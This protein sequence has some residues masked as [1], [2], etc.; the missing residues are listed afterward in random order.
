MVKRFRPLVNTGI[1]HPRDLPPSARSWSCEDLCVTPADGGDEAIFWK[2]KQRE[3]E[4]ISTLSGG[5]WVQH[6]SDEL[7]ASGISEIPEWYFI[8]SKGLKSLTVQRN[9]LRLLPDAIGNLKTIDTIVCDDNEIQGVL[10][11]SIGELSRLTGFTC[12]RN[13]LSG[14]VPS[15]FSNLTALSVLNLNSNRLAGMLPSLVRIR[16]DPVLDVDISNNFFSGL[17]EDIGDSINLYSL[18]AAGN[19]LRRLPRSIGR[20][21]SL[22]SIDLLDFSN[23][24]LDTVPRL[25]GVHKTLTKLKLANNE[26]KS[27]AGL[28][29]LLAGG[30]L[31]QLLLSGNQFSDVPAGIDTDGAA[32]TLLDM[33]RNPT[34]CKKVFGPEDGA[35]KAGTKIICKCADGFDG[36][37]CT[38]SDDPKTA[39]TRLVGSIRGGLLFADGVIA[40]AGQSSNITLELLSFKEGQYNHTHTLDANLDQSGISFDRCTD[41]YW[42]QKD[43]Y[44]AEIVPRYYPSV[45]DP[46]Q[47]LYAPFISD[48]PLSLYF[49]NVLLQ[50]SA[51]GADGTP[52]LLPSHPPMALVRSAFNDP[53]SAPYIT[54]TFVV[55]TG[56]TGIRTVVLPALL[57]DRLKGNPNIPTN[58]TISVKPKDADVKLCPSAVVTTLSVC[59]YALCPSGISGRIDANSNDWILSFP[60][61]T[62]GCRGTVVA[63]E[64]VS[65]ETLDVMDVEISPVGCFA[66]DPADPRS[67]TC[68]STGHGRCNTKGTGSLC[69]CDFGY[70]K[71]DGTECSRLKTCTGQ[72]VLS[73]T[74][75]DA[76]SNIPECVSCAKGAIPSDT[77]SACVPPACLDGCSCKFDKDG[78]EGAS[79]TVKCNDTRA[80]V[81]GAKSLPSMTAVLDLTDI[82]STDVDFGTILTPA[83]SS[84]PRMLIVDDRSVPGFVESE[85]RPSVIEIRLPLLSARAISAVDWALLRKTFSP[86][87]LPSGD[88]PDIRIVLSGRDGKPCP[89]GT[90][91]NT[92]GSGCEDCPRGQFFGFKVG[93][94]GPSPEIGCGSCE[95]GTFVNM[96]ANTDGNCQKCPKNTE[97][98]QPAG[99]RACPCLKNHYRRNRFD[100]C[101]P[102]E[103]VR[104]VECV[105]DTRVLSNG[106]YWRYDEDSL[107]HGAYVEWTS[108]LAVDAGYKYERLVPERSAVAEKCLREE[109]CAG[110][111]AENT[112]T[113]GFEGDLCASCSSGFRKFY[114][115]CLDCPSLGLSWFLLIFVILVVVYFAKRLFSANVRLAHEVGSLKLMSCIRPRDVVKLSHALSASADGSREIK[116]DEFEEAWRKV[117]PSRSTE[118]TT[119]HRKRV[120]E[121][122][123]PN[124][125]GSIP[126][127]R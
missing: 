51:S 38:D 52:L 112:C 81:P 120:F 44:P 9:K 56:P 19:N 48:S 11:P 117:C 92:D 78:L 49:G 62:L 37:G 20:A 30:K 94:A 6:R 61:T 125:N 76:V 127:D 74:N 53:F 85:N 24:I 82:H 101:F 46:T 75:V 63:T 60:G 115:D 41:I 73:R 55:E 66:R 17:P 7:I 43:G 27:C 105:N 23:N 83:N 40:R 95:D 67:A 1:A 71:S 72:Q 91:D 68:N 86:S 106:Y 12:A 45:G 5:T 14:E 2:C 110:G 29:E 99:Y 28:E 16:L 123:D 21:G 32:V 18:N 54:E 87:E 93:A 100:Q 108:D 25:A 88:N 77:E 69:V 84:L 64:E 15:S 96:T 124:G 58:V 13:Q 34:T 104:G 39:S 50:L 122:L 119:E 8:R 89:R 116:V 65:G 31:E 10:P 47:Q 36:P 102:C 4:H 79:L 3:Y 109:A 114:T 33:A 90:F 22:P 126:R 97:T 118:S 121:N 113:E 98:N 103:Q 70:V 42:C 107:T 80:L 111:L 59:R 26:L 35:L 57:R